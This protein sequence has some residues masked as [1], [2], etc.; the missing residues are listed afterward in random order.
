MNRSKHSLAQA[1][2]LDEIPP[3]RA[4]R[5]VLDVAASGLSMV[6]SHRVPRRYAPV[7][8]VGTSVMAGLVTAGYVLNDRAVGRVSATRLAGAATAGS[9]LTYASWGLSN[10]TDAVVDRRLREWGIPAPEVFAGVAS[11]LALRGVAA[12][13]EK[14]TVVPDAVMRE[15]RLGD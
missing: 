15:E 11:F 9:V 14:S 4:L 7:V 8:R 10:S 13:G 12:V 5:R 2:H 6:R 3:S 1:T